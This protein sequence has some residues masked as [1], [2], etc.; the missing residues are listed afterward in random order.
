ME[1]I[2]PERVTR[3]TITARAVTSARLVVRRINAD[4]LTARIILSP[5]VIT[6][7]P[8]TEED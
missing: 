2:R 5:I 3:D 4:T 1:P 8:P 7:E 6:A